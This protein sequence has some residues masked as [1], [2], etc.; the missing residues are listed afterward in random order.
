L[1]SNI[2]TVT[3]TSRKNIIGDIDLMCISVVN[4]KIMFRR[5][6]KME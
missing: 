3:I 1:G 5:L 2:Q 4:S 6:Q